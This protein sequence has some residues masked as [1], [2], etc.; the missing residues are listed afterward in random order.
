[1]N[2]LRD[3]GHAK[4]Y[5]EMQWLML[6]Q[7]TLD[8]YVIAT[9][10]QHSDREF[11]ERSANEL[12]IAIKWEGEGVNEKGI[13]FA[14]GKTIVTVDP[15]SFC[16]TEVETL[17]VDLTKAKANLGW[18]PKISFEQLVSEMVKVDLQ[19]AKKDE[20]CQCAGFQ[21]YTTMN[22]NSTIFIVGAGGMVSSATIRN[23]L[24]K[25]FNN[26]VGSF[27]SS[28]PQA[29]RFTLIPGSAD[30]PQGLRVLQIDLTRQDEV[31][32]FFQ[33]LK[34]DNV[35]LAAVKVGASMPAT[36]FRLSLSMKTLPSR[37]T[38]STQLTKAR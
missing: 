21:I 10:E 18:E 30:L 13:N 16:S 12:G 4:D 24:K 2:A 20:L 7:D 9:E 23:L 26:L 19:E 5:V 22:K 27:Q 8:D 15:R 14:S 31:I 38:S 25:G 33:E 32:R 3:W 28:T 11:V 37:E 1:M 34:S 29:D 35:F 17:L 36:P 6:Q